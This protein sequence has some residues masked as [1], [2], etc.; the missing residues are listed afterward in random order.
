VLAYLRKGEPFAEVGAGVRRVH[1]ACWRYVNETVELLAAR[2]PKLQAALREAQRQGLAYVIIDSTWSRSTASPPTGR[3]TPANAA[4]TAWT[5]RPSPPQPEPSCGYP[6]NCLAAPTTPPQ[7]G[8]WNILAA[9]RDAG[10]IALGDKGYRTGRL[11]KAIHVLQNYEVTAGWKGFIDANSGMSPLTELPRIRRR[12]TCVVE[13]CL[14]HGDPNRNI[15]RDS[16]KP[17]IV[18]WSA[19]HKREVARVSN[20]LCNAPRIRDAVHEHEK[21]TGIRIGGFRLQVTALPVAGSLFLPVASL[22][23]LVSVELLANRKEYVRRIIAHVAPWA[24]AV[25]FLDAAELTDV[26]TGSFDP[27]M[28]A[29]VALII[30]R[31][32]LRNRL[33]VAGTT[34]FPLVGE[35]TAMAYLAA[36]AHDAATRK[37]ITKISIT[38]RERAPDRSDLRLIHTRCHPR[39]PG[40]SS[41]RQGLAWAGCMENGHVR[42]WG[43]AGGANRPAQ[44]PSARVHPAWFGP[45]R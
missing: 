21:I 16:M 41:A 42:F 34:R 5:C 8:F 40:T 30:A 33:R 36:A 31:D 7:P 17:K 27:T 37:A 13:R 32:E 29:I 3:P 10:L 20:P 2:A 12:C 39:Q 22:H 15:K 44:P 14:R 18:S 4:G 6:D 9:L 25:T 43:G 28:V 26:L 19:A 23:I 35:A 38:L 24:N 45:K 11:A 1:Y